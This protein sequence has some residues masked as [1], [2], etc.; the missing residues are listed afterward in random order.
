MKILFVGGG[1]LGPVTP[2][3]AT[4]R[5]LKLREKRIECLWIGTPDGPERSVVEAENLPFF[6]L[7]VAK[8]P[9]YPSIAWLAFPWH[10]LRVRGQA[11]TLVRKLHPKAVVTVGGFTAVP[12]VRAATAHGIPCFTH[13]LD[14]EP[15]LTNRLIA[16]HCVSVT[17][18]FEYAKRPFGEG[19]Q[20]EPA[21]TPVRYELKELPTRQA[22]AKAFGLD[23]HQ[24]ITLVYGGGQGA[25]AFNLFLERTLEQWLCFTQV[26]HVTGRGKAEHLRHKQ[27]KGYVV[28][29]LLNTQEMLEAHAAADL[30]LTRGGMGTL[31]EIAALKKASIIVPIPDTHQEANAHAFEERGA[32]L[33]YNQA[34]STFDRD[35]LTSAKLLLCDRAERLA[36]GERA[37]TFFPT[38]DGSTFANRILH[39]LSSTV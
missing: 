34:S 31:S 28:R 22:A 27:R 33:V 30:E 17:T 3:L 25:Q 4:A 7:A 19:V 15:G 38:D 35:I 20:D 11:R 10:W 1:S 36:M 2:L 5:A 26:I 6:P 39:H 16:R 32:V 14:L 24:Y 29:S 18:S 12:L 9:R 13:Q 23:P 37:H 8:W 21:P